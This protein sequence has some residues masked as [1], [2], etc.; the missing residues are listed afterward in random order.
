MRSSHKFSRWLFY[1]VPVHINSRELVN[2]RIVSCIRACERLSLRNNT[3]FMAER[4]LLRDFLF[5][6][7][8]TTAAVPVVIPAA[9]SLG[10]P[11]PPSQVSSPPDPSQTHS[12][13]HALGHTGLERFARNEALGTVQIAALN[14]PQISSHDKRLTARCQGG[15]YGPACTRCFTHTNNS[16]VSCRACHSP[17]TNNVTLQ[18]LLLLLLQPPSCCDHTWEATKPA[19]SGRANTCVSPSCCCCT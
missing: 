12:A 17:M 13:P 7:A 4:Y 14:G 19:E 15:G 18:P 2:V 1:Y 5:L 6:L 11:H 16:T 10:P 3:G 8:C 9:A